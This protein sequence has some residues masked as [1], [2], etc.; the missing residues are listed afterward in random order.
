MLGS[1]GYTGFMRPTF[2]QP[3]RRH[4]L[5]FPIF[6][7]VVVAAGVLLWGP[8]T[9]I[10]RNPEKAR[11]WVESTGA[12]AP[13]VFIGIQVLQVAVFIIPG[14]IVQ[15]GGGYVFGLWEATVLS[16]LGILLGSII[17]FGVGRFLGRPF[18]ERLITRPAIERIEK[19]VSSGREAA[20]F[21]LLFVIPGFPKDALCYVA[22]MSSMDLKL[23]LVVSGL[24]RLPGI[25]GSA[26]MGSSAYDRRYGAAL[27][28][29]ITASCLFFLGL[30][31][32]DRI[33]DT[34]NRRLRRN[35]HKKNHQGQN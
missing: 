13:L 18:V 4:L 12:A 35:P 23:F 14:E 28:V 16:S 11:A 33:A 2:K 22:G 24:G 25:L 6:L 31:F 19:A 7:L 8:L 17:N 10:F 3:L 15:I 34:L 5:A 26:F 30:V 21:F 20:G 32:K 29:L 27:A 9:D 1:S